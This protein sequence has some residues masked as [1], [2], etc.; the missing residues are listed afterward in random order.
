[1]LSFSNGK[2]D[3]AYKQR[4]TILFFF[5]TLYIYASFYEG[6]IIILNGKEDKYISLIDDTAYYFRFILEHKF[7][8]QENKKF[9]LFSHKKDDKKS[10]YNDW[11]VEFLEKNF[12]SFSG[13]CPT[14]LKSPL[15]SGGLVEYRWDHKVSMPSFKDASF[16]NTLKAY[17]MI[18]PYAR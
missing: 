1:M 12:I 9:K 10:D 16:F 15:Q 2:F 17:F 4:Y 13:V 8:Q 6:S 14:Y 7:I 3:E 11:I 5:G 18:R